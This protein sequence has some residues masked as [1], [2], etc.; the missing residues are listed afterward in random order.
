LVRA[1]R[2]S[3]DG[4]VPERDQPQNSQVNAESEMSVGF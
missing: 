3:G 4:R 2:R 1:P